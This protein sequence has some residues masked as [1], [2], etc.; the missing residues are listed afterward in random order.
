MKT[1][2]E[3]MDCLIIPEGEEGIELKID[4]TNTGQPISF[5][6]PDCDVPM[7][8]QDFAAIAAEV[9]ADEKVHLLRA[10]L[11][12]IHWRNFYGSPI[13]PGQNL[14][15]ADVDRDLR[16]GIRRSHRHRDGKDGV[17]GTVRSARVII[18]A[19]PAPV[20]AGGGGI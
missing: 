12:E 18:Q 6:R 8:A 19:N 9:G 10:E 15:H 7:F 3:A 20:F 5:N 1:L 11:I 14:S 2:N 4:M 16:N 17:L 13:M